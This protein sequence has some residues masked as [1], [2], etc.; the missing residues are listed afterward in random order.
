MHTVTKTMLQVATVYQATR[1]HHTINAHASVTVLKPVI[2]QKWS[3]SPGLHP[4]LSARARGAGWSPDSAST[5]PPS[6]R[7]R[8]AHR[9]DATSTSVAPLINGF[10]RVTLV[11]RKLIVP[12]PP[13]TLYNQRGALAGWPLCP[14]PSDRADRAGI[15]APDAG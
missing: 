10:R 6:R 8:G 13:Q 2:F 9:R 1:L 5:N 11:L 3:L 4:Y 12:P 7:R 14:T 15:G